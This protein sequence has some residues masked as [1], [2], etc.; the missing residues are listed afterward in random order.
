MSRFISC[1]EENNSLFPILSQNRSLV[2]NG[3]ILKLKIHRSG[4]VS[5]NYTFIKRNAP[6]L[7]CHEND[8]T[9]KLIGSS[10]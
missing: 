10:I 7:Q 9:Y 6:S 5:H 4:D 8:E 2:F 1:G 3:N